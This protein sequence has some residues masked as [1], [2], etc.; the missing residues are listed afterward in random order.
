MRADPSGASR[1]RRSGGGVMLLGVAALA[2]ALASTH[3]GA[4]TSDL[5]LSC[6]NSDQG[7][8]SYAAVLTPL[9]S[10]T[11]FAYT[12]A[13]ASPVT[14][15]T[16]G[17]VYS[18]GD[19]VAT[20]LNN[21]A[22]T[23]ASASG[24]PSQQYT[25]LV[26]SVNVLRASN[27]E[28]Q[29][30][31]TV[32][33]AAPVL[34]AVSFASSAG[35][36]A[37]ASFT[38][39]FLSGGLGPY[40]TWLPYGSTNLVV[41]GTA[42]SGAVYASVNGPTLTNGAGPL[43]LTNTSGYTPF[44]TGRT[45][46]DGAANACTV[47]YPAIAASGWATGY[48]YVAT[49][50][51][52]NI[53]A[54]TLRLQ[55]TSVPNANSTSGTMLV[56]GASPVLAVNSTAGAAVTVTLT[57][58]QRWSVLAGD[59][60]AVCWDTP[61]I[62]FTSPVTGTYINQYGYNVG[63]NAG[64]G[65]GAFITTYFNVQGYG[66][67][68]NAYRAYSFQLRSS[69]GDASVL[70]TPSSSLALASGTPQTIRLVSPLD[71][72]YTFNVR[73]SCT[74]AVSLTYTIGATTTSVTTSPATYLLPTSAY[75]ALVPNAAT[76]AALTIT[77][78]AA[79]NVSVVFG[80]VT[81]VCTSGVACGSYSLAYGTNVVSIVSTFDGTVS[82]TV[83][84]PSVTNIDIACRDVN[85]NTTASVVM[86]PLFVSGTFTYSVSVP[87]SVIGCTIAATFS[88]SDS[89]Q[90][91]W[92]PNYYYA[93]TTVSGAVSTFFTLPA[94]S[95]FNF[96]AV[97]AIDGVYNVLITRAAQALTAVTLLPNGAGTSSIAYAPVFSGNNYIGAAATP[98][99]AGWSYLGCASEGNG[100]TLQAAYT[101]VPMLSYAVCIT[102]CTTGGRN[103]T[104]A[105]VEFMAEW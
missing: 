76:S 28:G 70:T 63:T 103:Y 51:S 75:S 77:F 95:T 55:T 24:A 94:G 47:V 66:G 15:C 11:T 22:A 73:V 64:G 32:T 16:L 57:A 42:S 38:P 56:V 41:G 92:R 79:S 30:V 69:F 21:G 91:S 13:V 45:Q 58:A 9:F 60:A 96:V 80:G 46:T 37:A 82:Y 71:G 20:S 33:R 7:Y 48:D 12:L 5:L 27:I 104:Y 67:A 89:L 44:A 23:A 19:L 25:L 98:L 62:P 61:T 85:A 1:M 83:S 4:S 74:S 105:G 8:S 65:L 90:Y 54:V 100:Q 49:A 52:S 72:Q 31:I 18:A 53:F 84:R 29:F 97:S 50:A 86:S 81:T 88:A 35:T 3:A 43:S 34:T 17:V 14:S 39:T 59:Y 26:G 93:A 2:L 99:P 101:L 102:Y 6:L 36:A 87:Y 10:A 40:T 78:T 68:A